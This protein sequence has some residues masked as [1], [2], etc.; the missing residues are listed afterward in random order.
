M[1]LD[2]LL[3]VS[4]VC[5]S[6]FLYKDSDMAKSFSLGIHECRNEK[7]VVMVFTAAFLPAKYI[8]KYE[9]VMEQL[10]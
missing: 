4:M 5:L 3:T 6:H 2:M 7:R 9:I 10:F 8:P 1:K